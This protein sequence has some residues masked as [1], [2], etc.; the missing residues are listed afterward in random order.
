M[1]A[2]SALPRVPAATARRL[3]LDAQGLLERPRAATVGSLYELIERLGF[4]QIDSINIVERAHHL[5]LASR[6]RG[7][8]PSLLERLLGPRDRRLFEHWTH[9]ASAIPSIWFPYWRVRFERYRKEVLARPW[10]R[11]RIGPEPE[12]VVAGVLE[13]LRR[14]GPLLSRD[15]EDERGPGA[16][17]AWWGWKPQK[18]A[19]EYLWRVGEL[20]IAGRVNFHKIYD[21]TERVLPEVVDLPRPSDEAHAAWACRTALERLGVA[22]PEEIMGFWR[23][24][25]SDEVRRWG[26]K[27]VGGGEVVVVEVEALDGSRPRKAYAPPDWEERAAAAPEALGRIR[28]LNPFD[29]ILRDRNRTLRLFGFDYRFEAFVPAGK[30]Q[31]GY[32]VLPILEGE[33]LI[34]R[35]DPKLYREEG[36]LDIAAIWWE[37]GIR[38]TRRRQEALEKAADRLART[39]GADRF[40]LPIGLS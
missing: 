5:T 9:D 35:L 27:A 29:P 33:R 13:R 7:Y 19:L 36:R 30:R 34:G 10:W 31:H 2:S 22:S 18:V 26:E 12:K 32:Y 16:D 25:K 24:I 21:L 38:L 23:A 28:I 6:L 11:E 20:A 37:P 1:S 14:E 17:K 3:L 8:R 40:T 4:V 39:V 15:F